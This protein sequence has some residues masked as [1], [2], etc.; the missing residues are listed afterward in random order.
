LSVRDVYPRTSQLHTTC[1]TPLKRK[2]PNKKKKKEKPIQDSTWVC[3][4][5]TH[6]HRNC[7]QHA[8]LP[9]KEKVKKGKEKTNQ[10]KTVLECAWR[11]PTNIAIANDMRDILSEIGRTLRTSQPRYHHLPTKTH[12]H[13]K[14]TT[15]ETCIPQ[16]RPAK[17][18][19]KRDLYTS[20]ETYRRDLQTKDPYT[21]KE[22]YKRDLYTSKETYKRDLTERTAKKTCIHRK[23]PA[24][25]TYRL[26]LGALCTSQLRYHHLLTETHIH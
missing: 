21:L 14:K 9:W 8:R 3:V 2:G 6:E 5:C 20:K 11:V 23:R 1:T 4:T 22:N 10:S 13:Q 26:S 15:K 12:I 16:K 17:E 7:T 24:E 18:N 25:E 19:C